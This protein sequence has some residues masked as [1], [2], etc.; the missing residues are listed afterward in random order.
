MFL[1]ETW[2]QRIAWRDNAVAHCAK[3]EGAGVESQGSRFSPY[4]LLPLTLPLIGSLFLN[5]QLPHVVMPTYERISS[6]G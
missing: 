1:I 5:D 3:G 6:G 2:G 4:C